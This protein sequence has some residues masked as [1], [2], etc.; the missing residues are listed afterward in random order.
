[1]EAKQIKEYY[2]EVLQPP[3]LYSGINLTPS[4]AIDTAV[5]L[6]RQIEALERRSKALKSEL[7]V[8]SNSYFAIS[9]S[10]RE[11]IAKDIAAGK[12]FTITK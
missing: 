8:I 1:M 11:A 7:R 2:A 4:E 9:E 5:A 10:D 6:S 3:P 12:M